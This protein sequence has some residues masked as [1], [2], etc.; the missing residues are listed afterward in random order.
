MNR[1]GLRA[2]VPGVVVTVLAAG[3]P[4]TSAQAAPARTR[5]VPAAVAAARSAPV[6]I[7]LITGDAVTVDGAGAIAVRPGPGRT[8]TRF[9]GQTIKGH[10]YVIPADALALLRA[11]RVDSRLFDIT[12]LAEFGYDDRRR[13]LPLLVSY[14]GGV[15]A[16]AATAATVPGARVVRDLPVVGALAVQADRPGRAALWTSLTA[17]TASARTLR[18]GVAKIWLDGKRKL[19][20]DVSVAQIGAPTAWK[21]GLDGTGTTVAVVD[22][23]IDATH[24]DLAGRISAAKNFTDDPDADDTVGHGTHVASTI[25][26]TGATSGGRFRGVAPG[27]KLLNAKVCTWESDC[28]ESWML[29]GMEWAAKQGAQVVNVSLGGMDLPGVDPLEAAVNTLTAA[30]GSLFVIAAGNDAPYLPVGSP[31]SADAA[32]AVGAVDRDDQLADFSSR[33]PRVGDGAVKPEITAPGVGIVAAKAA[34]DRIGEPA[35]VDGYTTMSGT[36]MATPHVAG[37]AAILT[38]QHP[39]WSPAKRK[40]ALMGAA[41]P[42]AGVDLFGQGAGRVDVARAIGQDVTTDEGS[43]TFG[44]ALWPHADDEAITKTVTYRNDGP[45]PVTLALTLEAT[46]PAGKAAPDGMFRLGD[47]TLNVPAGG[48]A[49]TTVTADTRV[50]GPDGV[51]S[52]AVTATAAGVRVRTPFIVDREVESYDITLVHT[53]RDGTPSVD[54]WTALNRL[55]GTGGYNVDAAEG[56]TRQRVAKG[57]YALWSFV[58]AGYDDENPANDQNT[59]LVRPKLVVDR[60]AT[61]TLKASAGRPV[62]VTVP[63]KGAVQSLGALGA[64]WTKEGLDAV[65]FDES[66]RGF[67]SAQIGPA[68]S[69]PGFLASADATFVRRDADDSAH[70]SPYRY[71]VAYFQKGRMFTGLKKAPKAKELAR[72]KET[73]Y[74]AATGAQG[75]TSVGGALPGTRRAFTVRQSSSFDLPLR[76]DQYVNADAGVLW[77]TDFDQEK[78]V[79]GDDWPETLSNAEGTPTR[80][81]AARTYSRQWNRAVF[82]P[83]VAGQAGVVRVGDTIYTWLP[84]TAEGTGTPSYSAV[85]KSRL[86]LYRNGVLV[87]EVTDAY[88]GFTVP[89]GKAAYRLE[90]SVERDPLHTLTTRSQAAWTFTSGHVA[91]ETIKPLALSTVRFLPPVSLTNTAAKAKKVSIDVRVDRQ[92]GS[93]AA[94]NKKLTVQVSYDDGRTWTAATVRGSGDHRTVVVK[95]RAKAGFVSLR[96]TATDTAGNTVKQTVIRAYRIG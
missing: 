22:S 50:A 42:T 19:D 23:G 14:P 74:R 1:R 37:A 85:T 25:A 53:N 27:A 11:D 67:F 31:A 72:V 45:Q 78:F 57:T 82:G 16:S 7:T 54:H 29:A 12:T 66:F 65:T 83:S 62:S 68:T 63:R 93:A 26:G 39:G 96:A 40:T 94:R 95:H 32:L 52:G 36:S 13:D 35:G 92:A 24:G 28:Q 51:H 55:D 77:S 84:M 70:N 8:G 9:L 17:G 4:G 75:S 73:F 6:T 71:D 58:H 10:R 2:V 88:D 20:L 59:L 64:S 5:T 69:Y 60:A 90:A 3:L 56:T 81:Q 41:K 89:A 33:G 87:K 15:Q 61:I 30:Y 49:T 43:V 86:A 46:D 21:A 38:Q 91:G 76:R 47:T 80:Y 48:T 79:E 18:P 44:T 34:H